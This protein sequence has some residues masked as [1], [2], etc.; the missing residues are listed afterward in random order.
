MPA[1]LARSGRLAFVLRTI[2]SCATSTG[3]AVWR[4]EVD[5]MSNVEQ[6]PKRRWRGVTVLAASAVLVLMIGGAFAVGQAVADQG[7]QETG[8]SG[9]TASTAGPRGTGR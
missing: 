2:S 9:Q 1:A 6:T 4:V 7:G 8:F 5:V 3:G